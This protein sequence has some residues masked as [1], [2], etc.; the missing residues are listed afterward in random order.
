MRDGAAGDINLDHLL[1][2]LVHPFADRVRNFARAPNT[3][4]NR[5]ESV[6]YDD[7]RTEAEVTTAFNDFRDA[8]NI[9]HALLEFIVGT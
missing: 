7:Q 5:T 1:A 4:A 6:A 8:G 2:R 9:D 3:H